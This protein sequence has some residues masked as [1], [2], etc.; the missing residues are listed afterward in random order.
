M[1]RK[2]FHNLRHDVRGMFFADL[3]DDSFARDSVRSEHDLAVVAA[4]DG[5]ALVAGALKLNGEALRR[6][7]RDGWFA[8]A[9]RESTVFLSACFHGV[10]YPEPSGCSWEALRAWLGN[11]GQDVPLSRE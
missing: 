7:V 4:A 5:F 9:W 6:A 10:A 11:G 2:H 8:A 1:A 3:N